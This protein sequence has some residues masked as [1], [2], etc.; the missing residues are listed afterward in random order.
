MD[1]FT[2]EPVF[3]NRDPETGDVVVGVLG[4]PN[5][6]HVYPDGATQPAASFAVDG[7]TLVSESPDV[8]WVADNA[9]L[10]GAGAFDTVAL[11]PIYPGTGVADLGSAIELPFFVEDICGLAHFVDDNNTPNNTTDDVLKF[12]GY[13]C[14]FDTYYIINAVTE[15]VEIKAVF[16]A[17]FFDPFFP[18]FGADAAEV[19]E[20]NGVDTLLVGKF[21]QVLQINLEAGGALES[22]FNTSLFSIQGLGGGGSILLADA[23]FPFN[24]VVGSRLPGEPV[25]EV[26]TA[27]DYQMQARVTMGGDVRTS[28][29]EDFSYVVLD[30]VTITITS[31]EDG[32]AV[33]ASPVPFTVEVDD[34]TVVQ[35]QLD[36]G[37]EEATLVGFDSPSTFDAAADQ[38]QYTTTGLFHFTDVF[39]G[40]DGLG[41]VAY[42]GQN[43]PLDYATGG[44]NAGYLETPEFTVGDGTT[45]TFGTYGHTEGGFGYDIMHGLFCQ[46]ES[47]EVI[48]QSVDIPEVLFGFGGPDGPG[49]PGGPGGPIGP[50]FGDFFGTSGEVY[51]GPFGFKFILVPQDR[52]ESGDRVL[53]DIVFPLAD[54]VPGLL[55]ETGTLRFN[56]DT[57]DPVLN[58]FTG[59]ILDN[60]EV[61]C[62]DITGDAFDVVD[63]VAE[64]DLPLEDGEN[65]WNCG[66]A[67]GCPA[68]AMARL[69]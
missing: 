36:Q 44:T 30:E 50:I 14:D 22:E 20:L 40:T 27:G 18:P 13:E 19:V 29:L 42:Y 37:V 25:P 49:G 6:L 1:E 54:F 52:R 5:T 4:D 35:V 45:V 51:D 16:N 63:G 69:A 32:E 26:T 33:I 28:T 67:A 65:R 11:I 17:N 8:L 23:G 58:N 66:L 21:N 34:P 38:A 47:C 53:T 48:F 57:V 68:P 2:N 59:W 39:E 41:D 15:V 12:V 24:R 55:S 43:G 64:F 3:V 56:F 7:G 9:R 46:G 61:T 10:D 62:A 60:L 31:P